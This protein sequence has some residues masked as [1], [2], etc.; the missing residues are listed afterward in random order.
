MIGGRVLVRHWEVIAKADFLVASSRFRRQRTRIFMGLSIFGGIWALIITPYL[1]DLIFQMRPEIM[2]LF[3]TSSPGMMRSMLLFLWLTVMVYPISYALQEIKI[4]QWEILL[5][6][7]VTT[8]NIVVGKFV[9][10]IPFYGFMIL[11]LAPVLLA[12]FI[13]VFSVSVIGQLV[14]YSA[15]ILLSISTL[16]ASTVLSSA[17]QMRLSQSHRGEEL[18]KMIA[19]VTSFLVIIPMMALMN[20]AGGMSDLLTMDVFLFFPFTWGADIATWGVF[21]FNGIGLSGEEIAVSVSMMQFDILVNTLLLL[22]FGLFVIV[23]GVVSADRLFVLEAGPRTEKVRTVGKENLILRGIRRLAPGSLG[24]LVVI[25]LKDFF[26]K[27]ENI[28]KVMLGLIITTLPPFIVGYMSATFPVEAPPLIVVIMSIFMMTMM[29]PMIGGLTF[30]GVGFL[31]SKNHLWIIQCAPR[32]ATKF[33]KARLLAFS[34][35]ALLMA[36]IPAIIITLLE[37]L[38]LLIGL[39]FTGYGFVLVS[40]SALIGTGIVA[41]NPTYETVK[42]SSFYVNT[43]ITTGIIL[44][45]ILIPLLVGI[46]YLPSLFVGIWGLFMGFLLLTGVPLMLIGALLCYLGIRNL[47]KPDS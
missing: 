10:K 4:G 36:I 14:M 8:R 18:A 41:L 16:W 40:G 32:G 2:T 35:V 19:M 31:E 43:I 27:P 37:R 5:S 39:A 9:G 38:D 44:V 6:S 25:S 20:F 21:L 15:I 17:I 30:G 13:V 42:S 11:F 29:F 3:R 28:A 34:L 45:S 33:V 22:A 23:V 46:R 7:S 1:M 26:R 12:P 47:S 24:V